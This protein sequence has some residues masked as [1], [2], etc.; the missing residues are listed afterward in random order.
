MNPANDCQLDSEL[1]NE[2]FAD[3]RQ[4]PVWL[5]QMVEILMALP[6]T[7]YYLNLTRLSRALRPC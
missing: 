7:A 6:Q 1:D 2:V 3:V 5:M 4:C